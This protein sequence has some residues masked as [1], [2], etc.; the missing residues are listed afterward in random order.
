KTFNGTKD[1]KN[2]HVTDSNT[3]SNFSTDNSYIAKS[4]EEPSKATATN[5]QN[6]SDNSSKSETSTP[7]LK[8][9]EINDK[10]TKTSSNSSNT[11]DSN[12]EEENN[13]KN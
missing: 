11:P 7:T 4:T 13:M 9:K 12:Q 5:K 2:T 8:K 1:P 3:E 10:T 6:I